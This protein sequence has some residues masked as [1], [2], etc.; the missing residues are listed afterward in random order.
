MQNQL[1]LHEIR[2]TA[3]EQGL[4]TPPEHGPILDAGC[5][6]GAFFALFSHLPDFNEKRPVIGID[7]L[8]ESILVSRQV[9]ERVNDAYLKEKGRLLRFAVLDPADLTK[10]DP[11][12]VFMN[13]KG[14]PALRNL[15]EVR[16]NSSLHWIRDNVAKYRVARMFHQ[17]LQPE[18][19]FCVSLS[20]MGTAEH[21]LTA[22]A[23]VIK[24]LGKF[25]ARNPRGYSPYEFQDDPVGSM[26]S[27]VIEKLIEGAGFN[28]VALVELPE[29]VPYTDPSDYSVAVKA[30]GF[31]EFIASLNRDY[32]KGQELDN[33]WLEIE[34][35]FIKELIRN[36]EW[37]TDWKKEGRK[38]PYRQHNIYAV[39]KK[40]ELGQVPISVHK[41]TKQ[42]KIKLSPVQ[43]LEDV[44]N[45]LYVTRSGAS[46][47]QKLGQKSH[48]PNL[49][50]ELV[51]NK[52]ELSPYTADVDLKPVLGALMSY[53]AS[54]W[55]VNDLKPVAKIV[56]SLKD[57]NLQVTLAVRTPSKESLEDYFKE[58]I[59]RQMRQT[60]VQVRLQEDEAQKMRTYEMLIPLKAAPTSA[61]GLA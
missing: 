32:W 17:M 13:E 8:K 40:V 28:A 35:E 2:L 53:A 12:H 61:L 15:S 22:Y 3:M 43:K 23:A 30:Y 24:G 5:G 42:E 27:H 33:L 19:I 59:A 58:D 16:S 25:S 46:I 11:M 39:F 21:F 48:N 50:F 31:D 6:K 55:D 1:T 34:Q 41:I 26:T 51:G 7:K 20:S 54:V 29:T 37:G 52:A 10:M 57:E 47:V 14:Y 60:G 45:E 38:Y 9:T 56:Y 44:L 36:G 4:I 18:G 49:Q